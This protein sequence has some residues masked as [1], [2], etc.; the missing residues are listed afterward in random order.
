MTPSDRTLIT[1][2]FR[3]TSARIVLDCIS[4]MAG[5]EVVVESGIEDRITI[6]L[7]D[8][9]WD[10]AVRVAADLAGCEAREASG[11]VVV[12]RPKR[13]TVEFAQTDLVEA[14]R[15]ITSGTGVEVAID[16]SVHAAV[17]MSLVNVPWRAA[18]EAVVR[19]AD[20]ALL[21][22]D[23]GRRLLVTMSRERL[24][25]DMEPRVF[26]FSFVQPLKGVRARITMT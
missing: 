19:L 13:L 17:S 18:L 14:V 24:P 5:R 22:Q 2:E 25:S 11:R 6:V 4:R 12:G 1:A 16:K 23:H 21:Q 9:P 8:C 26:R 3:D 20:C 7:Q 10:A 15:R